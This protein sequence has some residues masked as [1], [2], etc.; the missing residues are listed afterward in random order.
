MPFT[1]IGFERTGRTDSCGAKPPHNGFSTKSL[2]ERS[3]VPR[4]ILVSGIQGKEEAKFFVWTPGEVRAVLGDQASRFIQVY[5][6]TER[7]NFEGKNI[8]CRNL[9]CQV[10]VTEPE[11]LRVQPELQ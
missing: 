1:N 6:M 2:V 3:R 10:P 5:E 8:L 4:I 11:G 9:T 7:G